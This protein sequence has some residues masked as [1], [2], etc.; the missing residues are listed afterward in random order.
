MQ[1]V[2]LGN[3]ADVANWII[4]ARQLGQNLLGLGLKRLIALGAGAALTIVVL[5]VTAVQISK[6]PNEVLY[7]GLGR[8]EAGRVSAALKDANI[9]FDLSAD[10]STVYVRNGQAPRARMLLAQK[11]LPN[12]TTSGYELFD[13]I[14]SFGLTSFMQEVTK[15]RAIEGEL[16]RTIQ[17]LDGIRGARVHVVM[18]ERASFRSAQQEPSA[19][20]VLQI[21][22][23]RDD[24]PIAAIRHLVA[25]AIPKLST[26]NV[27]VVNS[28]GALLASSEDAD[29]TGSGSVR[30]LEAEISRNVRRNIFDAL[31]PYLA[32]QNLRVSV[33]TKVNVDR[34]EVAEKVF[35]P[36]TRVERSVRVSREATDSQDTPREMPTTVQQNLPRQEPA[37]AAERRKSEA[38]QRREE[39][40][41]Y[42][43]SSR[44]TNTVT[45]GYRIENLSIAIAINRLALPDHLR[46]PEAQAA[47]AAHLEELEQLVMSA[48]GFDK[49][50]SDTLK[51]VAL[52]M[53]NVG[54]EK[55]TVESRSNLMTF[56]PTAV[57]AALVLFVTLSVLFL[58]VRP[59]LRAVTAPPQL[60]A[61]ANAGP[62]AAS[63]KLLTSQVEQPAITEVPRPNVA[64]LAEARAHLKKVFEEDEDSAVAI[65]KELLAQERAA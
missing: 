62:D 16:A 64:S 13:K 46:K 22:G 33:T 52:D 45:A 61:P 2:V 12:S 17:M 38:T 37:S 60:S 55:S 36:N 25:S 58:G 11:G 14:G 23:P 51:I 44:T 18:Q 8:Q 3:V 54:S 59:L 50:R 6:P 34:Q 49:K 29:E 41:N 21:D 47:L 5:I 26:K 65:M 7:A 1:R 10:S 56:V 30:R 35:I 27:A 43:I 4:I 39:T 53:P 42:E 40:T 28:N 57:N 31:T 63:G 19:S 32:A 20:V 48:A 24:L 15:L 9:E